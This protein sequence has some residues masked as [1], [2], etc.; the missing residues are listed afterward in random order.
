MPCFIT[1]FKKSRNPF[2]WQKVII[3]MGIYW[4]IF[5]ENLS[6]DGTVV[7]SFGAIPVN[8]KSK[9]SQ[10]VSDTKTG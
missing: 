4:S 9:A 3:Y 2:I 8:S 1:D 6:V 10:F 5:G 7:T